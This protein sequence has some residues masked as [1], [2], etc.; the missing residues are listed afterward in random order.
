MYQP[1]PDPDKGQRQ[2]NLLFIFALGALIGASLAI[3]VI[4]FSRCGTSDQRPVTVSTTTTREVTRVVEVPKVVMREVEVTREVEVPVEIRH[5]I[6]VTQEVEV[7]VEV[8]RE[9]GVIRD[10]EV[11]VEVVHEI[12]VTREVEVPV[13]VTREVEA[14]RLV[15][16][17]PTATA[18]PPPPSTAA[19]LVERVK[20][21]IV[22]VEARSGGS[23]FGTTNAGSGFIFAVEWTTAFVA[24]NHHVVEGSN[25]VEVQIG[26]SSKYDALVLGWDAERDVAVLSICCSP[27]FSALSWSDS[28]PSEGQR[29]SRLDTRTAT[30]EILLQRLARYV[31]LMPSVWSVTLYRILRL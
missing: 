29:L 19:E 25:R 23:F 31:P 12:V 1:E 13:E 27:N 15:V 8:V 20:L 21:G 30:P 18:T 17:T 10:V 24:T 26:D 9:V 7:P 14:T 11:P 28:S 22:R 3:S 16:A 2:A 6:V 5:E 4:A